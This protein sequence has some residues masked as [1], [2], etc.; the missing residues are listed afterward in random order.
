MT[1]LQGIDFLSPMKPGIGTKAAHEFLRT[2]VLHLDEDR[3]LAPDIQAINQA[4]VNRSLLDVVEQAAG[5]L[6]V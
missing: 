4:I 6:A 3:I 1:A 2:L 5:P